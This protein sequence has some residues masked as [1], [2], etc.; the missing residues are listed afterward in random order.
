[1]TSSTSTSQRGLFSRV[2]FRG[3]VRPGKPS[4]DWLLHAALSIALGSLALVASAQIS[5]AH[6]G[7]Y[8]TGSYDAGAAEIA[9]FDPVNDRIW[10]TNAQANTVVGI[11]ASNP[12]ALSL[13]ITIPMAAYGGGVNSVVVLSN[14]F[15][16]AVESTPKTNPGKVV[17]FDLNGVFISE[18]TVGVLPD[19]ITVT[20]D[21]TKVLTANE[22]EPDNTYLID[23]IGSV[24]IIN[25]T[26]GLPSLTNANVTTLD[27][28]GFTPAMLPGV[29]LFG[30]G[31]SVAQDMEPE[32]VAISD[33]SQ[34]AFVTCQE[35]NAVAKI[36]LATN[37]ITQVTALGYKDHN[38]AGNGLDASDSPASINIANWPV[39]GFY[40]P[41]AVHAFTIGGQTYAVYANEGDAREYTGAPGYV[42][43]LR[44]S[45]AAVVLDPTV[46]PNAATLKNN[47]NL[48]RL[49]ISKAFG[50][51]DSDGDYDQLYSFGARSFSIRDANG[52]LVY[53]SGDDLEVIT[54]AAYPANFNASNTSNTLDTRSD[55]KGPEPEAVTTG[56]INGN[57]YAFVGLERIGGVVVF[58]VSNPFAPVFVQYLNNRNFAAATNTAGALDLGVEGIT[59]VSGADS[60]N[61]IPFLITANETS[62]TISTFQVL[63]CTV[64]ASC[65]DGNAAT[66]NDVFNASCVCAGTVP[67]FATG[68]V[69]VLQAG[70]GSGVLA[71]TGNPIVLREFTPSGTPGNTVTIPSTGGSPLIVSGSATSEGLLSRSADGTE[72]V[73][74]GYAQTLPNATPLAASTSATIN[75]GVGSVNAAG[76]YTRDYTSTTFFSGNNPRGAASDGTNF[77]GT[78]GTQGVNYWGP[79]TAATIATGK[80]NLRGAAVFNGQLYVSSASATGTPAV[81]GVF[82]VGN[83]LPTG[84]GQSLTTIAATANTNTNGFYFSPAGT[85]LYVTIGTGGIQKWVNSGSWSLAYT[86]TFADGANSVVA[87]FSG[88]NPILYV[89]SNAGGKLLKITD[90]NAGSGSVPVTPV[91]IATAAVNTAFRG[92]SFS[93][94]TPTTWYADVDA[95][96]F[97]DPNVTASACDQPVGF[98]GNNTDLCPAD[99]TKQAPGVCGCGTPD[100]GTTYYADVDGDGFGDPASPLAG[101]TCNVPAGYVANST[102]NCPAVVGVIGSTCNDGN[103]LTNNDVLNASCVCAGVLQT[104]FTGCSSSQSPYLKPLGAGRTT[105]SILTVGDLVGGY[106]LVGIPDGMGAYDNNNGT[107]TLLVNHELGATEGIARA[108]GSAGAFVSK[109][110]VNKSDLCVQSGADLITTVQLWNGSGFAPG[111]TAFNRFCAGD[112]AEPSAFYNAG[113]GKGTQERIY[114]NGEEAGTEGRAFGHIATGPNTGTTYQLPYLG[115]FSWENALANPATG[116]KTVVVG[117]DD[118]T[119][120]QVYFYIGSKQTT[121]TEIEKA[122][123][124]NG[125][126]FGVKVNGLTTEVSAS[127]VAPNTPFTLFDLGFVQNSTGVALNTASNTA[128][129]TSFLRPEDGAWDASNPSDFY[130]VTTNSF[131]APSRMYKLHFTDIL[132]PELGGTITAVLDGTEA[133]GQ[134]MM[135][136]MCIDQYGQA[137]IQEDPGNQAYIA[138]IHKYDIATDVLTP[139]AYHDSA[140]FLIGGANFLTQDEESSG[141]IDMKDI[142]GKGR[143]I[144]NDQ[145]HYAIPGELVQGGQ[146][147]EFRSGDTTNVCVPVAITAITDTTTLCSLDTL[148]LNVATS[149]TLPVTYSWSGTGT[150][151]F[152]NTNPSALVT[153]AASGFYILTA[154]NACGTA[155]DTV[156]VTATPAVTYYADVDGDTFGDPAV[157]SVSCTQPA[158]YVANSTDNCPAVVGVVGSTCNDGNPNTGNDML[159]ANCQCAG[160]VIDCLG[161]PGGS[162]LPGTACDDNNA[163]TGNDVYGANCVCAGQVIDCLGVP[164]GSALP[165]TAC[166][167]GNPLTTNDTYAANCTCAGVLPCNEE[168]LLTIDL[169]AFGAQTSWALKDNATLATV[170]SGG[171]YTNG[172]PG[173]VI[174]S[175]CVPTGCYKFELYDSFGDGISST[176]YVLTDDLGRRILDADGDFNSTSSVN[177]PGSADICVPV[178][179]TFLKPNWC[180]RTDLVPNDYVYARGVANATAYQFWFFDP[181]GSYSRR[182]QKSTTQCRLNFAGTPIPLGLELN[183]SV[184]ALVGGNYTQFGKV[185]TMVVNAPPGGGNLHSMIAD[186]VI[187][188]SLYPNPTNLGHVTMELEG[189]APEVEELVIVIFDLYG[190]QVVNLSIGT[191]GAEQMSTVLE[192]PNELATGL[193]TVQVMAGA[194]VHTQRLVIE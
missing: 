48:G 57:T 12:A 194:Q 60:P 122:G 163:A 25:I 59:F 106:D 164:G 121:G 18:V 36:N 58:N 14:G 20:P 40:M 70:D 1:M 93:P 42:E 116:D 141:I 181:H 107:F 54:A 16:V 75:R 7:T 104:A 47:A 178:G 5:I 19:M 173:Q 137:W 160:Q 55:D 68:N 151:L 133:V 81:T 89:V 52:T 179:P 100:V 23:P 117:T 84:T 66:V 69:V 13:F 142:L 101:F 168:L 61:G 193:Y 6:L 162:A 80:T 92:I 166:N 184:R 39:R 169:D 113:T 123:L 37:T 56:V 41:D 96:G 71:N 165:G 177:S 124:N 4:K 150:F 190:K 126:L 99:G 67:Q 154:T 8:A 109:W 94:C 65:D 50:D 86:L 134:K 78:G 29:R 144:I 46:F 175:M 188:M 145:A 35:N 138:R 167:D 149:G 135:D 111:T 91:Q 43:A 180:D 105:T 11:S 139:V 77:W 82:A 171:P 108:H 187:G 30:P 170:A 98:V 73:F 22:G 110:V 9:D 31:A 26:G 147:L 44:V 129:V 10:F 62:G 118:A 63:G 183:V 49:N 27:F 51:T 132:N 21:G 191:D 148:E 83:G 152:G 143:F 115:R 186:E 140:R 15:A 95:D 90:P 161:V 87:D 2:L 102:D 155:I 64:G 128:G 3:P 153:G 28:S 53:D 17:F 157:D 119:P 127:F 174:E 185:C 130:F 85:T 120:G 158:G 88:S 182:I 34:T 192:L 72:L 33:N 114:L 159:D 45:N 76:T 32:Y 189:I 131:T 97:G 125:K 38:V 74:T 136:N 146:L 24:S 112:L 176:G 79:S 156:V 172:T 103:P